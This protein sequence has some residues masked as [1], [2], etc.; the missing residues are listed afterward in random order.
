MKK[1]IV[2]KLTGNFEEFLH[3]TEEGIEFWFARDLQHLLGYGK[4]DNFNNV[5]SKAKTACEISG[6]NIPDHFADVGKMVDI[7]SGARKEIDDTM[8]TRFACYLVAQNGDPRKERIAFAQTYFAVQTRKAELI[9]QKILEFERVQ[10]RN[11]LVETEKE[12]SHIIF[13]QTGGNE[14]FALIRSKGD[15]ALFNRTTQQMKDKWDI[16]NKP[17]ADFMPTIL[18][19]AKDFATEITIFNAKQKKMNTEN[20]ISSEHITNNK[21]VRNT[22]LSRGIV[23]ENL[24]PE[25]DVKKL[26]RKLKSDEIKTLKDNKGFNVK[27]ED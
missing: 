10:V 21:T 27:A 24:S 23:P 14:N 25:E 4:W 9:E 19:K 7:G 8:L 5:I 15:Q 16:K 6:Q 17:L 22:L 11:K 1:E 12:L 18:L 2:Y 26:E 20:Q 13:E 3:L